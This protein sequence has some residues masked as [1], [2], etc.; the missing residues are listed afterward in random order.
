MEG[1]WVSENAV[2]ECFV[3]PPEPARQLLNGEA[4]NGVANIVRLDSDATFDAD[5]FV[6]T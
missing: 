1:E 5:S 6:D 3:G 4:K 2:T